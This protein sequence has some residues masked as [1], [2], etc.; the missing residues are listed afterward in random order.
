LCDSPL[1]GGRIATCVRKIA[2][3]RDRDPFSIPDKLGAER[4]EIES[5]HIPEAKTI[6]AVLDLVG[7]SIMLDSLAMLRRGSRSVWLAGW[8][9]CARD[10]VVPDHPARRV[11]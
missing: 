7:N 5:K 2:T 6:D 10:V 3:T 1:E 11:Q 4:C 8:A 9:A